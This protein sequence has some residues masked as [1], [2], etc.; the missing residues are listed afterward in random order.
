MALKQTLLAAGITLI[1]G[2]CAG[3]P[4]AGGSAPGLPAHQKQ[5]LS[6][7]YDIN[8]FYK[9]M[10]GPWSSQ[11]V[12]LI[13]DGPAELLWITGY[14]ARIVG[15]D[16]KMPM[17]QALMCHSN[18]DMVPTYHN[19]VFGQFRVTIGRLFNLS[20]GQYSVSLPKGF[21][22]P[23][24]SN[25]PLL[26]TSQVLNHD[27]KNPSFRV[28]YKATLTFVKDGSLKE[29]MKP[30]YQGIAYGLVQVDK[31]SSEQKGPTDAA[32]AKEEHGPSCFSGV[33]APA[34]IWFFSDSAGRKFSPHW[35][36]PPGKQIVRNDATEWL[37]LDFDTSIHYITVH[38]HPFAESMELI[39]A[40]TG[41]TL[42]KSRARNAK[43][44]IGLEH[45]DYFSSEAGLPVYKNHRY[46]VV[47]TYN[48][49]TKT[50]QDS[51]AAMHLYLLDKEFH[52]ENLNPKAPVPGQ[53]FFPSDL[54]PKI[55]R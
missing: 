1:C 15:E 42:F 4:L 12:Q 25:E 23:V 20:E 47:T 3:A 34:N 44:K 50:D 19:A 53:S 29:P 5:V 55:N 31:D 41:Q 40:T 13:P 27:F 39:D 43:N 37:G 9:S 8:K 21:G 51:M 2:G 17:P 28:R 26:L 52:R 16:G 11:T 10:Q 48:N 18:F 36:V 35:I 7:I 54:S 6:R 14:D 33:N 24:F 45:V 22:I 30:L 38:L 32:P 49:T 46:E